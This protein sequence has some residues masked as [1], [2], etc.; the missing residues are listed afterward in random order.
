MVD[1]GRLTKDSLERLWRDYCDDMHVES[2]SDL[3]SEHE[4]SIDFLV[5]CYRA[6]QSDLPEKD[7]KKIQSEIQHHY[8]QHIEMMEEIDER[9][10]RAATQGSFHLVGYKNRVAELAL[11]A[12]WLMNKAIKQEDAAGAAYYSFV[13]TT[14]VL[15][16]H[17]DA[18]LS[19]FKEIS[20]KEDRSNKQKKNKDDVLD[21]LLDSFFAHC[22]EENKE[23]KARYLKE[24]LKQVSGEN[25]LPNFTE[26][27][28]H[29]AP[30][31][32]DCY[33]GDIE[34]E[35]IKLVPNRAKK[36]GEPLYGWRTISDRLKLRKITELNSNDK[37][38]L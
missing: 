23:S 16:V 21:V 22:R 18:V 19:F 10:G 5:S 35:N 28:F 8:H 30:R 11:D 33:L 6:L 9:L 7:R 17:E 31:L 36:D 20:I 24:W 29:Y 2:A 14:L 13:Y 27:N 12:S 1:K 26:I 32:D 38:A 3:S 25:M 4:K 15:S 37:R 34:H